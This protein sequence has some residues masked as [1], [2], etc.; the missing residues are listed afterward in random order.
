MAS[1]IPS[2]GEVTRLLSEWSE[3]KQEA[4]EDLI[5]LVYSE[6]HRIARRTFAGQK[7]NHTLQ[8]TVLIHD[9]YIKLVNQGDRAFTSRT[10]FFA[11]AALA[12]RQVLVNYAVASLAEKRGGG[13]NT[14][15]IEDVE[16]A[17]QREAREVLELNEALKRLAEVDGR[18]ARVVELRYFGGLSI[19]ETAEALGISTITVTRDW[20][21]ARAWLARELERK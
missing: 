7:A 11:L 14:V 17:Q 10:H 16:P 1:Q 19:E 15:S 6:L 21:A 5:P 18:K 8:P 4:L 9:A 3:G 13:K 20:Q 2:D 12:M